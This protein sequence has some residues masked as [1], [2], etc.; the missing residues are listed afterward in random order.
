MPVQSHAHSA[1][2]G[3]VHVL[4]YYLRNDGKRELSYL[5]YTLTPLSGSPSELLARLCPVVVHFY[6]I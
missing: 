1:S 3:I 5:L 6:V 2:P 4:P